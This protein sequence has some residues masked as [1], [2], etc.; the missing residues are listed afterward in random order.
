MKK[1]L[2]INQEHKRQKIKLYC[3]LYEKLTSIIINTKLF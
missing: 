1:L 2:S 3:L